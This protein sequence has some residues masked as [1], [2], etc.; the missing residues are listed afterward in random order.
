MN[1]APSAFDAPHVP[2]HLAAGHQPAGQHA[3]GH[4]AVG[5]Q[6]AG[7]VLQNVAITVD[8]RVLVAIGHLHVAPGQVTA[9]MGPSGS[10]K[11]SLLAWMTGLLDAPLQGT[12]TVHV[13]DENLSLLPTEQ[14][15]LGLMQQD[16]VLFPHLNVVDNLLFALPRGLPNLHQGSSHH[17]RQHHRQLRR[18]LALRALDNVHLRDLA[19]RAP[20]AL[21]GG[22]RQRVA[23]ARTLLAQ[24][25]ALLLDEPFSRLHQNLRAELRALV[26]RL[27]AQAGLPVLIVTHDPQDVPTGAQVVTLETPPAQ[28]HR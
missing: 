9:L 27:A 26:W 3:A 6:P 22:E 19:T 11:S 25:R 4:H 2:G 5:Q 28:G 10:G 17:H 7:L 13:N 15:R 12:G 21:S 24:P 20:N 1:S 23:L 14:R 18:D 16:D 8:N